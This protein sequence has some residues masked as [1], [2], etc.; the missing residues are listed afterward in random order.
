MW[1]VLDGPL[2][3][4][5]V[6]LGPHGGGITLNP[7]R[8]WSD[9][10]PF[11]VLRRSHSKTKQTWQEER[12]EIRWLNC[13]LTIRPSLKRTLSNP[14]K[15]AKGGGSW[16][17]GWKKRALKH[18]LSEREWEGKRERALLLR[19]RQGKKEQRA[20]YNT[21]QCCSAPLSG[22]E[23]RTQ[24]NGLLSLRSRP[25]APEEAFFSAHMVM[26]ALQDAPLAEASCSASGHMRSTVSPQW[27]LQH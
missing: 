3:G 8:Y 7:D 9:L 15:V 6:F 11:P 23:G 17:K 24:D 18:P 12:G 25:A 2:S 19:A 22:M 14:A 13:S 4:K 26:A 5:F 20:V 1:C 10:Q 16:R 21:V 27:P